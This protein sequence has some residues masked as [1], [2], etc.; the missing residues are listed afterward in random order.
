MRK[1]TNPTSTPTNSI[2]W[3][4]VAADLVRRGLASIAILDKPIDTD[5][6][7]KKGSRHA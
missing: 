7:K 3:E 6:D 1:N 5:H 4:P 2:D